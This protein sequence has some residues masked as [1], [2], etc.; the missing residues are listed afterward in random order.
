MIEN[1]EQLIKKANLIESEEERVKYIMKYLFDTVE[2]N[3]SYLLASGYMKENISS[4]GSLKIGPNPFKSG[5]VKIS[6]K[7]EEKE[8]DDSYVIEQKPKDGSSKIFNKI[9]ELQ[10]KSNGDFEKFQT[11]L[12]ELLEHELSKHLGNEELVKSEVSFLMKKINILMKSLVP[13]NFGGKS[14]YAFLDISAVLSRF[15]SDNRGEKFFPPVIKNGLLKR[16]VCEH[17]SNY[18]VDLF[19]KIGIEV[20]RIDGTSELKHTWITVKVDGIYKS[21]DLTRAIFI[22]D[23]FRG[24]PESQT[25]E[26]WLFSDFEDTFVMQPTRTITGHDLYENENGELESIPFERVIDGSNF[27]QQ[28]LIN[29]FNT[30]KHKK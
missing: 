1:V 19:P 23:H 7:G 20:H 9:V 14:S 16:G 26:M 17:Y 12:Q 13:I 27:S 4:L 10:E 22:R 18:L 15:L 3:Y 5:K 2:Y 28:E 24:I 25:A 29:V 6:F 21:I 30:R 11:D 8:V